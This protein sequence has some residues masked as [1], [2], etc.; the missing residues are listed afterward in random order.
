MEKPAAVRHRNGLLLTIKFYAILSTK[1][2]KELIMR[3]GTVN[4]DGFGV[5]KV[6]R[7]A[8]NIPCFS[9]LKSSRQST[10]NQVRKLHKNRVYSTITVHPS[11]KSTKT[12]SKYAIK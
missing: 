8:A 3:F 12:K 1:S 2:R 6:I 5:V 10:I 11:I 9:S 7:N 4:F